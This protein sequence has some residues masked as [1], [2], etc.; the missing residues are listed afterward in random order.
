MRLAGGS[1]LVPGFELGVRFD[2]GDAESGFGA[3][4]GV[5]LAW[6]DAKRGLSAE[7]RGR[8]LLAHAAAEF[9][10]RELSGEISWDPVEVGRGPRL[11]EA[12]TLGGASSGGAEALF[13]LGTLEGLAANGNG[14]GDDIEAGSWISESV[15]ASAFRAAAGRWC[16]HLDSVFRRRFKSG[17]S[18]GA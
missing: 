16:P 6:S 11:S 12:Q 2:G 4:I 10:E 13:G 1:M 3:D 7:L 17:S 15:T 9:R 18:G 5:S 8:G 14:F